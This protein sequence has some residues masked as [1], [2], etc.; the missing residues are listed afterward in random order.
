MSYYTKHLLLASYLASYNPSRSDDKLFTRLHERKKKKTV[1]R[2]AK[3]TKTKD[4]KIVAT[5]SKHRKIS[6]QLL[7]PQP[8][9]LERLLAIFHAIL[10]DKAPSG[11]AD[12]LCQ[13]A[14]LSNLRM[15]VKASSSA[16][17]EGI[18]SIDG[19]AKWRINM[20]WEYIL[21]L[22]KNVDIDMVDFIVE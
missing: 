6:R 3:T 4:G 12:V 17:G 18:A 19:S 9:S 16:G 10:P 1:T 14:T 7:G 20:G 5:P 22:G 8:F 13:I 11:N 15:L 21:Q 2:K